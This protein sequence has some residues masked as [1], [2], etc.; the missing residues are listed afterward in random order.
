MLN[1]SKVNLITN[2][3]IKLKKKNLTDK[4]NE[5]CYHYEEKNKVRYEK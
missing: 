5:I 4:L 1:T 3:Y 2:L